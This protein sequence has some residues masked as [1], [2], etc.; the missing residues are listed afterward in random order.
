ETEIFF[1]GGGA[2]YMDARSIANGSLL[3]VKYSGNQTVEKISENLKN[4][5]DDAEY[6]PGMWEFVDVSKAKWD[7]MGFDSMRRV[8]RLAN[9]IGVCPGK[10]KRIS[11]FAPGDTSFGMARMFTTLNEIEPG[12]ILADVFRTEGEALKFLNRPENHLASL[13]ERPAP[14]RQTPH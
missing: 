11:F 5:Y 2:M 13:L 10:E 6:F 9:L 8:V 7:A 3:Y 14:F 12:T 4:L 1:S